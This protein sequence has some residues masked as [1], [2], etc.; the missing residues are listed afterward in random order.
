MPTFKYHA[1][2]ETLSK[3]GAP[4]KNTEKM[5]FPQGGTGT[6]ELGKCNKGAQVELSDES[7]DKGIPKAPPALLF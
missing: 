4:D 3:G 1:G 7:G 5:G 6:K 2:E